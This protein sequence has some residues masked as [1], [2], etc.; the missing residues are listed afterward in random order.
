M[1]NSHPYAELEGTAQWSVI[2]RALIELAENRD[3]VETTAHEY[4]VGYLCKALAEPARLAPQQIVQPLSPEGRRN[5]LTNIR[6]AVR[7]ANTT[8][9]DL[10]EELIA[11][12]R[13][14]AQHD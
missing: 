7:K 9:R 4:I 2:D 11:E 5:A 1:P 8:N 3:L 12:R 13:L 14:E 6:A 10:A